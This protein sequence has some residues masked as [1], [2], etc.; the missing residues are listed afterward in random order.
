MLA[1]SES[2]RGD[3]VVQVAGYDD[4]NNFYIVAGQQLSIISVDVR[5]WKSVLSRTA[6]GFG[7]GSNCMEG[8]AVGFGD[9]IGMESAPCAKTNESE[10]KRCCSHSSSLARDELAVTRLVEAKRNHRQV[11]PYRADG[12]RRGKQ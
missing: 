11:V 10:S 3:L 9:R 7:A 1:G 6:A 4:I 8:R 12:I 5:P 2:G